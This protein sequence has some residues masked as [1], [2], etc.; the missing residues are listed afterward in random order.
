MNQ[1]RNSSHDGK[2]TAMESKSEMRLRLSAA[3]PHSSQGLLGQLI[4][5]V[6]EIRPKIIA[7]YSPLPSEPDVSEFNSWAQ[8]NGY[9]IL[10][11]RVSGHV[12]VFGEGSLAKG[13][14]GISEPQ[15]P[16]IALE[17][18][19]LLLI[20]ALAIDKNGHRLGKGKGFYDRALATHKPA[21]VFAVVFECEYPLDIKTQPHDQKVDG[22][23]TPITR[24]RFQG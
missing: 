4:L 11:P 18:L 17:N 12:L 15:G 10:L 7:S 19:D 9:Q 23:V 8:V 1:R 6:L 5:L 24:G 13:S 14:F 3:R 22:F 2:I 16:E 21:E 20:P